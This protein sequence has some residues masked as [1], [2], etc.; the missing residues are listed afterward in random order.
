MLLEYMLKLRWGGN[1]AL[2]IPSVDPGIRAQG[3]ERKVEL[4]LCAINA[5][6]KN[7]SLVSEY[8]KPACKERNPLPLH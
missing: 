7:N 1:T 5:G 4:L 3:P 2:G 6:A 8:D